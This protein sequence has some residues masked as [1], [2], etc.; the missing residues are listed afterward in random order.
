MLHGRSDVRTISHLEHIRQLS[1]G[2][3]YGCLLQF[4]LC[5][6]LNYVDEH[7]ESLLYVVQENSGG[8]QVER[9]SVA[10]VT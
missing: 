4:I 9:A 7:E 1:F 6:D 3:E 5:C 2:S 8:E 10:H